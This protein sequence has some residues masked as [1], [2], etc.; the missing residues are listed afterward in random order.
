[1]MLFPAID[2]L[3]VVAV[4]LPFFSFLIK[5]YE[6]F[7]WLRNALVVSGILISLYFI[8]WLW[9]TPVVDT[10]RVDYLSVFFSCL[11]LFFGF[12]TVLYSFRKKLDS[13]FYSLFFFIL[14]GLVGIT[15]A[16][17]FFT[18]WVF[19]ELM[20]IPSFALVWYGSNK[21]L[22][23]GAALKYIFMSVAGSAALLFAI[24]LLYGSTGTVNF[25]DLSNVAEAPLKII[26]VLIIAGFG[27][28]A[29][30]F[31]FHFWA[32][33]VY[34]ASNISTSA[35]FASVLSK[36]GIFGLIRV[37][38]LILPFSLWNNALTILALMSMTFGGFMALIQND[39]KRLLA[40]ASISHI[41][42]IIFAISLGTIEGLVAGLFHTLNHAILMASLFF[43]LGVF[44]VVNIHKLKTIPR[45]YKL[46]LLVSALAAGGMPPFNGFISE[47]LILQASMGSGWL[48]F[49]VVLLFNMFL[50]LAVFLRLIK[51]V[52]RLKT[53]NTKVN[54]YSMVPIIILLLLIL[55]FGIYPGPILN[56]LQK[57]ASSLF[58]LF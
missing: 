45:F 11:F 25:S 23:V 4:I 52:S 31:P 18:L 24:S 3:L 54:F 50:I 19:W 2:V 22:A 58:I 8:I 41:G 30:I 53:E 17:D 14:A 56:V 33:D 5:K 48:I 40:F 37:L 10:F 42:F 9:Y 34:Q 27:V 7:R 15:I 55:I 57:V 51:N 43:C 13:K 29:V 44:S 36:S 49:S 47:V 1:M 32:P 28:E 20:S 38:Y 6:K 21:K 35:L 26:I 16:K 12:L 46:I 39:L